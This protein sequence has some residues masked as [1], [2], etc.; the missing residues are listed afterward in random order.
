MNHP[1]CLTLLL[2]LV[3]CFPSFADDT[4]QRRAAIEC[5][6]RAGLPNFLAKVAKGESVNVAYLGGSITAASGWRVQSLKWFQ[7]QNP[8]ANFTEIHAAIGGTGSDLGVFRLHN[9][10]LR[11][12]PDLMF[13]EFAVNDGGT[14]REQIHKA[15]EGIVRQTWKDNPTTDICFV[16]TLSHPFLEEI[17]NG[18]MSNAASSME[19]VA[20]RY[21]IPS[22]HFGVEVAKLESQGDL[23]FKA[24]KPANPEEQPIVF[25]TDGVH[26]LN[27]TGHRLYTAAIARSWPAIETASGQPQAHPLGEPLRKDNWENAK[28]V[29]ITAD[30]LRGSWQK[31]QPNNPVASRFKKHFPDMYQAMEPGAKLAFTLNGTAASVFH[32][33]G[34]DGSELSVQVD[35]RPPSTHKSIDG[36]CTYHRM[37]K[38]GLSTNLEPGIH[39]IS[40]TV[41]P[42]QLDKREILFEGKR[43]YFDEHPDLYADQTWYVGSLLII[44]DILPPD[45]TK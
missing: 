41:T 8:Q 13:V 45:T 31:L 18:Q 1:I 33:L 42:T 21:Q 26:P 16:Y 29:A 19:E 37:S 17:K 14:S 7:D 15:M 2:S 34:P 40:V 30:M 20:D 28:Q 32:L 5:T 3:C 44:G 11:H 43:D 35:Q 25:S 36:Y 9:D 22:I 39:E 38:L 4:Q 12:H 24:D 6:P 10:V 27:E 23:I